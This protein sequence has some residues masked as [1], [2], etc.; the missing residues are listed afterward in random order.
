M[1]MITEM[2]K[3]YGGLPPVAMCLSTAENLRDYGTNAHAKRVSRMVGKP[4]P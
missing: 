4:L 1:N 3:P 2:M